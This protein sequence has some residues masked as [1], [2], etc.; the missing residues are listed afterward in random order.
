MT[1]IVR[2]GKWSLLEPHSLSIGL[3]DWTIKQ[4]RQN[5][6]N[7][8]CV[9]IC[10]KFSVKCEASH[11][12]KS[13]RFYAFDKACGEGG[14]EGMVAERYKS[15]N[16]KT[17]SITRVSSL[18]TMNIWQLGAAL[19]LIMNGGQC[20]SQHSFFQLPFDCRLSWQRMGYTLVALTGGI[21]CA[22]CC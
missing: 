8:K 2:G 18:M 9:S 21:V 19:S 22:A 17:I 13:R 12:N 6:N 4:K 7:G 11:N 10:S 1:A 3:L 14:G 20:Q 5:R 16:L 15:C